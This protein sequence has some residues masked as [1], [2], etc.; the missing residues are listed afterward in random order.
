MTTDK[1]KDGLG[2]FVV[3]AL[4]GGYF[5]LTKVIWPW[6]TDNQRILMF[7]L[8]AIVALVALFFALRGLCRKFVFLLRYGKLFKKK[9]HDLDKSRQ[10]V[11]SIRSELSSLKIKIGE[12]ASACNKL[13]NEK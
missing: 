6:V 1:E 7:S 11:E 8:C 5:L 12:L 4:A 13:K 3:I 10:C 2:C 9:K